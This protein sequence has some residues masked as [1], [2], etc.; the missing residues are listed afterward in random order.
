VSN[1]LATMYAGRVTGSSLEE[2]LESLAE[3]FRERQIPFEV[4]RTRELPTL[5]AT[6]CPYPELA[7][8]DR[9]ICAME[10]M[11]FSDLVGENLRLSNCRLDGHNC[12]TFEPAQS[13]YR[14][15]SEPVSYEAS[16]TPGSLT[17]RPQ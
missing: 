9:G 15:I 5:H 1:R 13:T 7:E 4:D 10:R 12:C 6:A 16:Q 11:L 3:L 8:L 14:T 2:R 17:D